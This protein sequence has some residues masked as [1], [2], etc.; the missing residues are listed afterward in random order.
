M[1]NESP[2]ELMQKYPIF[3]L[4]VLVLFAGALAKPVFGLNLKWAIYVGVLIMIAGLAIPKI[5]G[6]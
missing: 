5:T 3:A 2:A 4:G 6:R 1:A